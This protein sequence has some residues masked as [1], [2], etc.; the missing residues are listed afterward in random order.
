MKAQAAIL[1]SARV[2]AVFWCATLW[3]PA[4]AAPPKY[5]VVDLG[6]TDRPGAGLEWRPTGPVP[7]FSTPSALPSL[8]GDPTF[9]QVNAFFS[10]FHLPGFTGGLGVAVGVSPLPNNGNPPSSHA[11]LWQFQGANVIATD[12]GVLPGAFS[13]PGTGPNSNANALNALGDIVG[14]S[15]SGFGTF[16]PGF[17]YESSHAFLWTNN[18]MHDLGTLAT[19]EYNSCANGIND[20]IE[21][22]GWTNTVSTADNSVLQRAF[23]YTGGKMYNLSF[24]IANSSTI[25][26]TDALAINCQGNIAAVGYDTKFGPGHTH[27]YLLNRVGTPRSCPL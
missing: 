19:V 7:S 13:Q 11:V 22:V 23:V 20:F 27:T 9:N 10:S 4:M 15:D 12:L 24:F 26:L 2:V 5:T 25:R 18:V 8:G 6:R 16:H 3:L 17:P 14:C 1:L 21:I